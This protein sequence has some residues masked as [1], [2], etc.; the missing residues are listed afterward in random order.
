MEAARRPHGL[1]VLIGI[2]TERICS[3]F[4]DQ[5][6]R[7]R[8]TRPG[9][10]APPVAVPLAAI[11]LAVDRKIAAHQP[12][13]KARPTV[14][15]SFTCPVPGRFRLGAQHCL[16]DSSRAVSTM[17]AHVAVDAR[18][19]TPP[20]RAPQTA[21]PARAGSTA[22]GGEGVVAKGPWRLDLRQPLGSSTMR[23]GSRRRHWWQSRKQRSRPGPS[24]YRAT[25]RSSRQRYWP[26]RRR[27]SAGWRGRRCWRR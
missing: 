27:R 21:L 14:F 5:Q 25:H 26:D 13:E 3:P 15:L 20:A 8:P 19:R 22:G 23:P 17:S 10:R 24:G 1:P 7:R 4:V 2:A 6:H 18:A 9:P 11:D 12:A 16:F